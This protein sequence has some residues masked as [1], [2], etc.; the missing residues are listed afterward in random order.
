MFEDADEVGGAFSFAD[1]EAREATRFTDSL[2]SLDNRMY[3]EIRSPDAIVKKKQDNDERTMNYYSEGY[4][5][6]YETVEDA[7]VLQWQKSDF[8]FLR[9]TGQALPV[10][11][12][13]S[14]EIGR[15]T[16]SPVAS[17]DPSRNYIEST[18]TV[19]HFT[20][21]QLDNL[22]IVGKRITIGCHASANANTLPAACAYKADVSEEEEEIF[23]SHGILEEVLEF[24]AGHDDVAD[25]DE[26]GA[27]PSPE[28][29]VR[30][31]VLASMVD[32]IW[33]DVVAAM[34]PL[35]HDVL[36]AANDSN[37]PYAVDQAPA[38]AKAGEG[39]DYDR[40]FGF[41]SDDDGGW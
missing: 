27:V 33:P 34:K 8:K 30:T 38:K 21:H 7:E 10:S 36:V 19:P 23:V 9:V 40:G 13:N 25:M 20:D 12:G 41:A 2:R 17:L 28:T 16:D 39:M 6:N 35:I 3:T 26:D 11:H 29:S 15:Y 24:S 1:M 18:D 22:T 32:T 4:E 37:I 31:E 5:A 14:A